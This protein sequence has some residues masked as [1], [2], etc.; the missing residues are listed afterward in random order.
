MTR[1]ITHRSSAYVP[2][3][4]LRR[5]YTYCK[6]A[7]VSKQF[8]FIVRL[9]VACAAQGV[10]YDVQWSQRFGSD[11]THAPGDRIV[12]SMVA[13]ITAAGASIP[14]AKPLQ[15]P[16]ALRLV[17]EW[18][19]RFHEAVYKLDAWGVKAQDGTIT[20][21]AGFAIE[22]S[23][24]LS[25]VC[26]T[27]TGEWGSDSG[28]ADPLGATWLLTHTASGLGFGLSLKFARAV[29]ALLAAAS[30]PVDWT[31][32]LDTLQGPAFQRAG[33]SVQ[34]EFGSARERDS[35]TRRLEAMERAA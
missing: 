5:P 12:N 29:K 22:H 11:G 27:S 10:E 15:K 13:T 23:S 30:H 24:G 16:P 3:L 26:A 31:A 21:R 25:L 34:A 1:T 32:D 2:S 14:V 4:E 33:L 8:R 7:E 19:P 9:A 28:D 35:A 20:R 17:Q 6:T 18:K